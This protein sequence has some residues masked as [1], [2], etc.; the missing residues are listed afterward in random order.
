MNTERG[1]TTPHKTLRPKPGLS[2]WTLVFQ[3][4]ETPVELGCGPL[5][6]SALARVYIARH[7]R[8]KPRVNEGPQ[9]P[10]KPEADHPAK[11]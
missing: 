8:R 11:E 10:F 9:V 3:I 2:I 4:E 5:L 1:V 6:D 7:S